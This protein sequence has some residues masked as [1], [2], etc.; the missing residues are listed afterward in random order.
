MKWLIV[1]AGFTGAVLAERVAARLDHQVLLIDARDHVGGNAFDCRDSAGV[2]IHRYGPHIFHT[3][4]VKVAAYLSRF[5]AWRPYQHKVRGWV[6][7]AL[8]PLPFNLT[9]MEMVFGV[10][11]GAR[12]NKLL[13]DEYGAG[14][15]VP[16]LKMRSSQAAEVR[17]V[18]DV[19]YEKVFL[20]YTLK[21]WGLRP[22]ELD[23]AVSAR[24]PVHLSC[25]ERYFQDQFQHMPRDGYAAM[26]ARMLD[27]PRIERRTGVTFAQVAESERFDRLIFTGPIDEFFDRRHGALPYRSLRF[28]LHT[29]RAREPIQSVA[30]ENFPTPAAQH[31]FTRST[32]FRLIT[33]QSD[34]DYTTRARDFP[35]PHVPGVNEPYYPVPCEESSNLFRRYAADAARLKSVLFAGRLADYQYYDMDQAVGRA[36]ALFEKTIAPGAAQQ[37]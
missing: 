18:A 7:G 32:E 23:A 6:D 14:A 33:G 26:F 19:I 27:H 25:D 8:V 15:R 5:T 17:K 37:N 3:N 4:A 35:E 21:Q 31:P 10:A 13:T 9:S 1:G 20:H 16:I 12:L 29:S 24:V 36:L 28:E 11:A 30:T 34:V 2:L 22:E